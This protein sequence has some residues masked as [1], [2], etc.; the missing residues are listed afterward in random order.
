MLIYYYCFFAVSRANI[1][2]SSS[3]FIIFFLYSSF[4]HSF[5]VLLSNIFSLILI[6]FS[7]SML[8]SFVSSLYYYANVR[9]SSISSVLYSILYYDFLLWINVFGIFN[10]SPFNSCYFT[11][12]TSLIRIY[13]CINTSSSCSYFDSIC[14]ICSLRR[15]IEFN[16]ILSPVSTIFGLL[17][18]FFCGAITSSSNVNT[19]HSYLG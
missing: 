10:L 2:N 12:D 9:G 17:S 3:S 19:Y 14:L 7:G 1:N 8:S 16:I 5:S 18:S 11:I 15:M 4:C 13:V 6:M